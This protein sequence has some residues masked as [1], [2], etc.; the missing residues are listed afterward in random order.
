ME[1]QSRTNRTFCQIPIVLL[2]MLH[3]P[4]DNSKFNKLKDAT[5]H[6]I[7]IHNFNELQH[8]KNA[9]L[10]TPELLDALAKVDGSTND[11]L[12]QLAQKN[13]L[14]R[15]LQDQQEERQKGETLKLSCL[16]CPTKHLS[17]LQWF[18]HSFKKHDFNIGRPDNVVYLN[19]FIDLVKIELNDL[20][21]ICCHS[22]FSS[23]HL[24][25]QHMRQ[26]RHFRVDPKMSNFDKFYVVNYLPPENSSKDLNIG[27][28]SDKS[29]SGWSDLEDEI[30]L[31]QC[32]FCPLKFEAF[33]CLDH[34]KNAHNYDLI[35]IQRVH[36]LDV[37]GTIRLINYARETKSNKVPPPSDVMWEDP[38]WL[39]P[40]IPDDALLTV[41]DEP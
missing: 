41:I 37:Y 9:T 4:R 35:K 18:E 2:K 26:K 28:E 6:L 21:C 14:N 17:R 40:R 30:V 15:V 3:C 31:A 10:C 25:L 5:D 39:F 13:A 32:V 1:R 20:S 8:L 33:A 19:E 7:N 23:R 24:L 16:F 34:L 38:K 12:L 36:H 22:R 29:D 11:T 27:E